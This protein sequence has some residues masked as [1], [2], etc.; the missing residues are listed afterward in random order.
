MLKEIVAGFVDHSWQGSSCVLP[1]AWRWLCTTGHTK[2]ST[3]PNETNSSSSTAQGR[4]DHDDDEAQQGQQVAHLKSE[5]H[6]DEHGH[7][8][9]TKNEPEISTT[10]ES[11]HRDH[12]VDVVSESNHKSIQTNDGKRNRT[13]ESAQHNGASKQHDIHANA[14]NS[15]TTHTDTIQPEQEKKKIW[16]AS[17]VMK[18]SR[19]HDVEIKRPRDD[20]ELEH[21][22]ALLAHE[23]TKEYEGSKDA[24][25][26]D[27]RVSGV[28]KACVPCMRVRI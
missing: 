28:F 4:H 6:A 22:Q 5:S 9:H 18:N 24:S 12:A 26:K 25:L 2:N 17:D 7:A 11:S 21:T 20:S 3:G 15:S 23:G 1:R 27:G 10:Q 19:E 8:G 16:S 14:D 13:K